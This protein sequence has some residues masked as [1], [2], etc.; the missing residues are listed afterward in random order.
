MQDSNI[1]LFNRAK[2]NTV[3]KLY[4]AYFKLDN[5][6]NIS[7]SNG[8]KY[9]EVEMRLLETTAA[10]FYKSFVGKKL[11]TYIGF[12]YK[13]V[14]SLIRNMK[15]NLNGVEDSK[16]RMAFELRNICLDQLSLFVLAEFEELEVVNG[17]LKDK[18]VSK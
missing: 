7:K 16:Q 5:I 18:A 9:N 4:Y 2:F 3:E 11:K 17:T 15:I 1:V 13:I 14:I 8:D 10:G 12:N 6:R